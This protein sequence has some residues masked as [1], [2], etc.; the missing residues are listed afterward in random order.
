M[1]RRLAG[2]ICCLCLAVAFSGCA[3]KE[4]RAECDALQSQISALSKNQKTWRLAVM[5]TLS[6]RAWNSGERHWMEHVAVLSSV[7]PD[8]EE[9]FV[10][11]FSTG[12]RSNVVLSLR[13]SRSDAIAEL[14]SRLRELGYRLKSP[15][16]TPVAGRSGYGFQITMELVYPG[17]KS[18][19]FEGLELPAER[20]EDDMSLLP[21]KEQKDLLKRA[22]KQPEVVA[23]RPKA[24]PPERVENVQSGQETQNGDNQNLRKGNRG[25]KKGGNR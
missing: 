12:T 4:G 5:Q 3:K 6:T 21:I 25:G 1:N 18:P 23:E 2:G 7:L 15:A 16:V 8:A 17:K 22:G 14:E 10:P 24:A 19:S 13:V 9:A 20:P 11:S